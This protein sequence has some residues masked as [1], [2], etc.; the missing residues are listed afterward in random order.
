LSNR[1]PPVTPKEAESIAKALGWIPDPNPPRTAGDHKYFRHPDK[2]LPLQIDQTSGPLG[3]SYIRMM[4]KRMNVT[5]EEFYGAT[6]KTAKKIGLK[7]K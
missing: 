5:R 6:R 7:I 1:F 4:L 2:T 3:E